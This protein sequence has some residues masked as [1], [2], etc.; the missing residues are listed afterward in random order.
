[1][2][3]YTQYKPSKALCNFIECFW[4]CRSPASSMSSLERLIPGGRT[5]VIFNFSNPM[6]FLMTDDLLNGQAITHVSV[7]GQ[8]SHIYYTKQ[9]GDTNLLGA[10]FKP[11]GLSAFTNITAAVLLNQI[12]PVEDIL[13]SAAK[14]WKS[15]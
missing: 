11:G 10:R 14:E 6:Q 8:R 7:M 1:M 5:E 12:V 4:I 9:N 15:R 3:R 13:S 2:L